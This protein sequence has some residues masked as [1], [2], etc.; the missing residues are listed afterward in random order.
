MI[1]ASIDS[2]AFEDKLRIF[3][4]GLGNIY[5]EL[6]KEVGDKMTAE[7]KANAPRR[8]GKLAD[9]FKFIFT[10]DAEAM[11][12]SRKGVKKSG[13][14]YANMVESG[15]NIEAK[16]KEYLIFK[17]N[18][19]WVKVKSVKVQT[20]PFFWNVKEDYFGL[21]GKGWKE[22]ALALERKMNEELK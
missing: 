5:K 14:Y 9:S 13:V 8:T 6:L 20:Q 12:T 15:A 7:V 3:S 4:S 22:L 11:L 2:K 21:G 1:T 18:G 16:N 10:D 19:N 17:I